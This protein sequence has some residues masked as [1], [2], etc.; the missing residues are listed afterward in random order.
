LQRQPAHGGAGN[1]GAGQRARGGRRG[2]PA[3]AAARLGDAFVTGPLRATFDEADR[4]SVE[5]A[6]APAAV[7]AL[8]A[9]GG[10]EPEA[11]AHAHARDRDDRPVAGAD[12]L[13]VRDPDAVDAPDH[14][15]ELPCGGAGLRGHSS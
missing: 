8:I 13:A 4:L 14:P 9:R 12:G 3:G 7:A 11:A 1:G 10:T 2:Q 6:S 15:P 5:G